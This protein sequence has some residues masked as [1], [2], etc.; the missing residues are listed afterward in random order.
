MAEV[1]YQPQTQTQVAIDQG[2]RSH[3]LKVYN[4]M[5]AGLGITGVAAVATYM[6]AVDSSSGTQQ[7]T[8]LGTMLFASCSKSDSTKTQAAGTAETTAAGTEAAPPQL[9]WRRRR[10]V[11]CGRSDYRAPPHRRAATPAPAPARHRPGT[12]RCR[13]DRRRPPAPSM[14][15]AAAPRSRYAPASDYRACDRGDGHH[16]GCARTG[17]AGRW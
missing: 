14:R 10:P 7:L 11:V 1:R 5:A 2:L 15:Q 13:W 16:A 3:M 9:R 4:Y 6:M 17:G 8:P 12:S